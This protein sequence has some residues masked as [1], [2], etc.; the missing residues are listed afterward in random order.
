MEVT[1]ELRTE[2]GSFRLDLVLGGD[3]RGGVSLTGATERVLG[4]RKVGLVAIVVGSA[5]R[6]STGDE[7]V[8][9]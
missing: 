8:A 5:E 4:L 9:L 6:P 2:S 1:E 3:W 7:T